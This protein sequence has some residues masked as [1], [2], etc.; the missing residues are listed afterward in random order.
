[1]NIPSYGIYGHSFYGHKAFLSGTVKMLDLKNRKI[2]FEK[3]LTLSGEIIEGVNHFK[4]LEKDNLRLLKD[5]MNKI[6]S[7]FAEKIISDLNSDN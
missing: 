4:D 3:Q 1:M 5:T 7:E 2:I 6:T